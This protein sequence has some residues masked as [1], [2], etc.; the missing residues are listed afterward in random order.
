M[1]PLTPFCS[2][3][4][5][6]GEES[7]RQSHGRVDMP[8]SQPLVSIVIPT[9][10]R[11]DGFLPMALRSVCMQTYASLDIFVADNASTDRTGELVRSFADARIRYYRHGENIGSA[12]NTNFC[13]AQSKGEYTLLLNDDDLIDP[14]FVATCMATLRTGR[15]PGLIRT[16]TRIIDDAGK[17]LRSYANNSSGHSFEGFIAD[18]VSGRT[19]PYLCS[20]LFLTHPLQQIGMNSRR[21]MWDDVLTELRIMAAHG[22]V[23]V[24]TIHA[25]FREHPGE[26]TARARPEDWIED[27]KQLLEAA[28]E[29][30]AVDPAG[31]RAR[32]APFVAKL[33]YNRIENMRAPIWKRL[34]AHMHVWRRLGVRPPCRAWLERL[35]SPK[36]WYRRFRAWGWVRSVAVLRRTRP[37]AER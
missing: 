28:V 30:S 17:V 26:I 22:R 31:T 3:D 35:L 27:S 2:K 8:S 29:L 34:S 24:P 13:I 36:P 12:R 4:A 32:L 6:E 16:G 7:P 23:E 1:L 18:W 10:N 33:D 25:S 15:R 21:H 20:T 14:D 11:A 37:S 5:T 19:A 9:F